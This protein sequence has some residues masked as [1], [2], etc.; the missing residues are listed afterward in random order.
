MGARRGPTRA[1]L[2]LGQLKERAKPG[3]VNGYRC[4][5]HAPPQMQRPVAMRWLLRWLC[6]QL[7]D[8]A[9]RSAV[10]KPSEFSRG[11]SLVGGHSLAPQSGAEF[12]QGSAD[13]FPCPP[14]WPM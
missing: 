12:S 13:G 7:S 2:G 6:V 10:T 11:L 3:T 1:R 5:K 4:R 9:R 8:D 14:Q